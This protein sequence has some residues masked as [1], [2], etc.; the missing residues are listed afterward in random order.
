MAEY[1]CK[2]CGAPIKAGKE[3][4]EVVC[5]YCG[6]LQTI[7]HENVREAE[8]DRKIKIYEKVLAENEKTAI[9]V[10]R[11][12]RLIDEVNREYAGSKAV[13]D[14]LDRFREILGYIVES[15]DTS[16]YIPLIVYVIHSKNPL[17][18]AEGTIYKVVVSDPHGRMAEKFVYDAEKPFG[19]MICKRDTPFV[20][21]LEYPFSDPECQKEPLQ[22]EEVAIYTDGTKIPVV[23]IKEKALRYEVIVD[24]LWQ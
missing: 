15:G 8:E 21:I 3:G 23:A 12:K 9:W 13:G 11:A 4:K 19:M 17:S 18:A 20:K 14:A 16:G 2:S 1:I 7:D 5:D 6:F 22:E 10:E 24:Y